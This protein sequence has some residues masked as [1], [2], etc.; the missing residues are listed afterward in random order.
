MVAE[1]VVSGSP[2]TKSKDL[3]QVPRTEHSLTKKIRLTKK[4]A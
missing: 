3:K 4:K 1:E 2:K